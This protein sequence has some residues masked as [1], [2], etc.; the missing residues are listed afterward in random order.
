[1]DVLEIRQ[2]QK[3]FGSKKVLCGLNL[4]VPEHG[5]LGFIGR[6]GAGKTTAM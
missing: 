3:S 1:M 5:I 2:L 6:N 4:S